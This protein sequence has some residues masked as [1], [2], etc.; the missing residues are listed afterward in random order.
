MAETQ[1][2]K[3]FYRI[4]DVARMTGFSRAGIYLQVKN[5]TFP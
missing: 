3:R 1:N 4:A 5:G 2:E